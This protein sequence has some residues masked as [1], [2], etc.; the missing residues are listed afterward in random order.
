MEMKP[1]GRVLEDSG[2]RWKILTEVV[3]NCKKE[4]RKIHTFN[5]RESVGWTDCGVEPVEEEELNLKPV[6]ENRV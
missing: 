3:N 6:L 1:A 4:K 2:I 5:Q